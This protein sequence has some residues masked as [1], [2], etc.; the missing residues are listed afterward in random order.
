VSDRASPPEQPGAPR[1]RLAYFVAPSRQIAGIERVT[2][3][4]ADGLARA[5]ADDLEVHVI[6]S[7]DYPE[8]DGL[9]Q[10]AAYRLHR[11]GRDRIR[12][13]GPA[14]RRCVAEN[15]LEVLVVPQVEATI[16]AWLS[17]RGTGVGALV[18]HLHGNPRIEFDEGTR[19]SRLAFRFFKQA[20]SPRVP[21]VFA[22]SPSLRDYAAGTIAAKSR[23]VYVPNPVAARPGAA[24]AWLDDPDVFR[25]VSVG[26]LTRQ[27]GQDLLLDAV[28]A[29]R[30]R[31]SRFRVTIVGGGPEMGA[32]KAR[33]ASLGLDDVVTFTGHAPPDEHLVRADCLVLASRWEGFG[34]VLVEALQRGVPLLAADC[35]F[36]PRDIITDPR[37]GTLVR[38]DDVAA[39][40]EGL[41]AMSSRTRRADEVE[42]RVQA[43]KQFEPDEAVAAHFRAISAL[44]LGRPGSAPR[45]PDGLS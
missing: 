21:A 4:I 36:G 18:P 12:A 27:K 42:A 8:L 6:Y 15:R 31:L 14:L 19:R 3:E 43:A 38:P 32:L 10:T 44:G 26:R 13:V 22:V 16:V 25:V 2:H 28:A 20:V 7:S 29:A 30:P 39:L 9:A 33:S 23:V 37:L 45:L 35:D 40:A 17:T 34:V 41:V 5:Y 24:T 1:L 11:L